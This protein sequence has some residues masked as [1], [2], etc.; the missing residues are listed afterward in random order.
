MSNVDN[1]RQIIDEAPAYKRLR[2]R[3]S[4]IALL[5]LTILTI[6]AQ[7]PSTRGQ[8]ISIVTVENNSTHAT[9]NLDIQSALNSLIWNAY[10]KEQSQLSITDEGR[11]FLAKSSSGLQ[12]ATFENP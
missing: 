12:I 9:G 4:I 7:K 6:L 5:E 3:R 10:V 11:I 8:L 2:E 1:Y